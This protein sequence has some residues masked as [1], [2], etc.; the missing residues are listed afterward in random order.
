LNGNE[1]NSGAVISLRD[2]YRTYEMGDFT[3]NALDGVSVDIQKNEYSLV[4]STAP[5]G[6]TISLMAGT[7]AT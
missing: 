7:W 5:R 4:A 6:V 3:L 2:V 1:A